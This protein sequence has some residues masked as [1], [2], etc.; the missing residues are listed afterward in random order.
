MLERYFI[1]P[2]TVDRIRGSWIGGPIERYVEWLTEC[3]YST[4]TIC[5]RVPILIRFGQYAWRGGARAP[6][7]LPAYVDPFTERWVRDHA[8]NC[9]TQEARK[10]V[11]ED[12]RN[13]IQQ[14]LR[15][16]IKGYCG[17]GRKKKEFEPFSNQ[18]PGFFQYLKE[19]RGLRETS[20]EHYKHYLRGFEAFLSKIALHHLSELS[21]PVLSAFITDYK[22][23][24]SKS[25]LRGLCSTLSVFLKYLHR[26]RLTPKDLSRS[27]GGPQ[28]Y[29]HSDIP[30]S[31]TWD[32]VRKLLDSVDRRTPLGKRDYAILLLLVTYG[33]RAKEVAGLTLDAIDWKRERLRIPERKA[34]HSTAYPLSSLVGEAIVDYLRHGRPE[35]SDRHL[36]FRVLAPPTPYTYSAI[37]GRVSHYLRKAGIQV[38]RSGSHTLRHTCVQRLIDS[39][40]SLKSIGD[41]VGHRST[42]STEIYTKVSIEALREVAMG[43]GEVIG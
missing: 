24:L 3:R 28:I 35:T 8:H 7:Q 43:D 36:F 23:N 27:I 31:I 20:I 18:A 22:G 40:F 1:R 14:M 26:E 38:H 30:R 19:E 5:R 13:P 15:L 4:R 16:I 25:S 17:I 11:A 34:G 42:S 39:G 9:T 12:A 6:D 37:S 21:P 33:L 32:E 2:D 10:Q 41:Y 29:R